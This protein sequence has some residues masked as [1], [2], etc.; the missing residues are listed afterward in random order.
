M[1]LVLCQASKGR[2]PGFGKFPT[3]LKV[4]YKFHKIQTKALRGLFFF[5]SSWN[6]TNVYIENMNS[7]SQGNSEKGEDACSAT[8]TG[9]EVVRVQAPCRPHHP[10]NGRWP[11]PQAHTPH[12]FTL[13]C[14]YLKAMS[15]SVDQA[16]HGSS[17]LPS[18]C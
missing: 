4:I 13:L 3:L 12:G 2:R 14:V 6:K 16:D 18:E 1:T 9:R 5:F 10:V 7:L 17:L 15:G 8:E 11:R